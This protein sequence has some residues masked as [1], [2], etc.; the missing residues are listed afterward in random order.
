MRHFGGYLHFRV[1]HKLMRKK[2]LIILLKHEFSSR[3]RS[4]L[5]IQ[6]SAP[7]SI[8]GMIIPSMMRRLTSFH[9]S[10]DASISLRGMPNT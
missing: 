1:M 7:S 4:E 2:D 3:R 6:C 10:L 9:V 8:V 5:T